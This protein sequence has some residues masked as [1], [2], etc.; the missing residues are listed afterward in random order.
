MSETYCGNE[1]WWRRAL[2]GALT[3]AEQQ[4]WAAHRSTCERCRQEWDALLEVDRLFTTVPV[5]TPPENFVM[6]T[7]ARVKGALRRQRRARIW[8]SVFLVGVVLLIELL[9]CGVVF[10]DL[11]QAGDAVFASRDLLLQ[12]L[13]RLWVGF[14]AFSDVVLPLLLGMLLLSLLVVMPN[15]VLATLA[16]VLLRRRRAYPR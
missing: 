8:G 2:E 14:I 1:E 10:S 4:R 3:P 12:A 6:E 5:P 15:G 9:I 11:V 16:L 7:A 13:M